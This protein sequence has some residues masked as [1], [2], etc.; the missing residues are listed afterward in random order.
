MEMY[1]PPHP[2]KI[3]LEDWIKPLNFS[4]SEFALRIG[5]SRKN[6]SGIVNAKCGIS[7]EMSLKLSKALNTS[8]EL[9]LRLQVKFDLWQAK[10]HVDLDSIEVIAF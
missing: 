8:P 7:P 1:N 6:L 5:T 3:L 9:W 4:I 10:Q 2:G